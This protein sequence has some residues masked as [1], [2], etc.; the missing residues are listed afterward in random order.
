MKMFLVSVVLVFVG[1][2][3]TYAQSLKFVGDVNI[4]AE[5]GQPIPLNPETDCD[6]VR[7]TVL[8]KGAWII[9]GKQLPVL[10]KSAIFSSN[11]PGIYT[12]LIDGAKVV[13][14]K[15]KL[16]QLK[17]IINVGK[18]PTPVDPINP[19]DP[20]TPQPKDEFTS[21]VVAAWKSDPPVQNADLTVGNNVEAAAFLSSVYKVATTQGGLIDTSDTVD[22]VFTKMQSIRRKKYGD[23]FLPKTR[24]ILEELIKKELP[25]PNTGTPLTPELKTKIK[26]VF[27]K[28]SVALE[29]CQ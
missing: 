18:T 9:D 27:N 3:N 21:K 16:A 15:G 1:G 26:N 25:A 22:K 5:V 7:Y 19:I 2:F 28:I 20:P 8:S 10:Q 29:A 23:D 17:L 14:G 13:D 12:V 24:D 6:D 4:Q 11:T